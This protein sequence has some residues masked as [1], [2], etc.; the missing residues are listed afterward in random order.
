MIAFLKGEVVSVQDNPSRVVVMTSGGVGYSVLLP[1]VVNESLNPTAGEEVSLHIYY[2]VSERQPL[3]LL[4][5]FESASDREFF[6]QFIQVEGIGPMRAATALTMPVPTL[7][8]AI[9]TEDLVTLTLLPGVGQRGAQKIIAT[10]K[11]KVAEAAGRSAEIARRR[12]PAPDMRSDVV[13]VLVNLGFR[14]NEAATMVDQTIAL[15]PDLADDAQG[16]LREIFRHSGPAAAFR[17]E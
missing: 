13:A 1:S 9:E 5:G 16:L 12:E 6:E 14:E 8:Y 2:S 10:L 17:S 3:P 7:A 15:E 11:G 4:V